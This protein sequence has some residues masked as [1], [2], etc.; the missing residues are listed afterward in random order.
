MD[1]AEYHRKL[2]NAF[3]QAEAAGLSNYAYNPYF[4]RLMR[5]WGF[6]P[7]PLHYAGWTATFRLIPF[8]TIAMSG[9]L[10]LVHGLSD[11]FSAPNARAEGVEFLV[12]TGVTGLI[13]GAFASLG[14]VWEAQADRRKHNLA[15]WEEL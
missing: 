2:E 6:K 9:V 13:G 1:S 4:D 5:F 14:Q 8:F 3:T 11:F 10:F 12:R 15:R 7:V